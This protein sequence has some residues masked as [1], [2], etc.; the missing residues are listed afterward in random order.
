VEVSLLETMTEWMGYPLYYAYD[1]ASP[2]GRSGAAHATICP[3]GPFQTGDGSTVL[4]GVQNEREWASFCEVVLEQPALARDP[5]Y[6]S[7]VLRHEARAEVESRIREV[8]A[9]LTSGAV[10]ARLDRA[11]IANARLNE[12][13]DV[14]AHP[15]LHA[16][17]RFASIMTPAGEVPALLPPALPEGVSPRMDPVPAVGQHTDAILAELGFA[18]SIDRLRADAAI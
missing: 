15:Q 8:F 4:L 6:A 7:N 10:M 5:R 17:G 1:G 9:T 2:P 18:S 12:M 13:K 3:Y 11:Q 14:W 16:R